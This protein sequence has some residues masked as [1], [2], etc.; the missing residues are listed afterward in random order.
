MQVHVCTKH[1]LTQYVGVGCKCIM[2]YYYIMQGKIGYDH[3]EFDN[4][5]LNIAVASP[6]SILYG[7]IIVM[8]CNLSKCGYCSPM[9]VHQR[10]KYRFD[11]LI[12]YRPYLFMYVWLGIHITYMR[13]QS[14]SWYTIY[15]NIGTCVVYRCR[16]FS[17]NRSV[18]FRASIKLFSN[19]L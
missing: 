12:Y 7:T 5:Q 1:T 10:H 4:K 19:I 13:Q 2:Y 8:L 17:A 6:N 11:R 9:D 18:H 15:T 14:C 16:H 3:F